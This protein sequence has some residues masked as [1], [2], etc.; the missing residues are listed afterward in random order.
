MFQTKHSAF[1]GILICVLVILACRTT[2]VILSQVTVVP[3]RTPRATFT[4]LPTS[5]PGQVSTRTP[6]VYTVVPLT[7]LP[8]PTSHLTPTGNRTVVMPTVDP[9]PTQPRIYRYKSANYGCEFSGQTFIQGRVRDADGNLL[10]GVEVVMSGSPGGAI[11][12]QKTSGDDG[13]GFYS[14]IVVEGY[15]SAPGQSRWIWVV[16]GGKRASDYV[17][18]DFNNLP[19][20]NSASCWRGFV[21]FVQQQ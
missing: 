3:T 14:I 12:D 19:D 20:T 11:A 17:Q 16:E 4:P 1:I 2:D 5:V 18:F 15:K 9:W 8:R 6:A 21:D 13:A 7:P 10:N